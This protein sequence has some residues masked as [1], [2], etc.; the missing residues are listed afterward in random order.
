[1][2][3]KGSSCSLD[4]D[5]E[6]ET[7]LFQVDPNAIPGSTAK[8]QVS[9]NYTVIKE[10]PKTIQPAGDIDISL[11]DPVVAGQT[12]YITTDADYP[13]PSYSVRV[14]YITSFNGNTWYADVGEHSGSSLRTFSHLI[15][16]VFLASMQVQ[17]LIDGVVVSEG[18]VITF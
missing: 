2:N 10:Y 3:Y 7:V 17:V 6:G 9:H 16:G 13:A 15:N 5:G 14:K 8:L 1:M 11:S 18:D 4:P 12:V